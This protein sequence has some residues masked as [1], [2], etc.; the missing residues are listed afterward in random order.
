MLKGKGSNL[1]ADEKSI[2]FFITKLFFDDVFGTRSDI[3]RV[4]GQ[5]Q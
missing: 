5:F 4:D 1:P 2:S 3:F